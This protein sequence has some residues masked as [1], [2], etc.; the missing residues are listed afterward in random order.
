M[1]WSVLHCT[2]I[3]AIRGNEGGRLIVELGSRVHFTSLHLYGYWNHKL[4]ERTRPSYA[5]S[6]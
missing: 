5:I 1:A 2:A 6:W 3:T 4:R